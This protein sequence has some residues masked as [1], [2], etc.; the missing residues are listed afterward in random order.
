LERVGTNSASYAEIAG[1]Y[2]TPET[3]QNMEAT[4][5]AIPATERISGPKV[6]VSE[7]YTWTMER[8]T[9]PTRLKTIRPRLT[10]L[11]KRLCYLTGVAV[12]EASRHRLQQ[13]Q[14]L[15]PT[16]Q[17]L[18]TGTMEKNLPKSL[19]VLTF[20]CGTIGMNSIFLLVELLFQRYYRVNF[21]RFELEINRNEFYLL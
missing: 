19:V 18:S 6:M 13:Q 15:L 7:D 2:L 11:P 3:S 9:Q 5:F 12:P 4:C 20:S 1:S 21:G 8:I 17:V 14:N 10:W 16:K